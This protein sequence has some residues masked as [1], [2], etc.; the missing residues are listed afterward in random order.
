MRVVYGLTLA[1]AIAVAAPTMMAQQ[2]DMATKVSGGITVPGWTGKADATKENAGLTINDLKF[3]PVQGGFHITTGP[4]ATFWHPKN[5]VAGNYTVKATFAEPAFMARMNHPH[6]YG[7]MIAGNDLGTDNMSLLY[8]AAYG[9]GRFIVRGF[10]PTSFMMNAR[11]EANPAIKT[12]EKGQPVTQEIA[13]SVAG[14]KVTCSVNGTVVGT[15][16]KADLVAAGKLKSTD[17]IAGLRFGHNTEAVV[18]G[19]SITKQ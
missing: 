12:V 14:D 17:G 4:S 3:A 5:V 15:Y 16:A 13:M 19:W 2:A 6:P 9:N 18:T 8:C 11:G 10:G 1:A 7:I